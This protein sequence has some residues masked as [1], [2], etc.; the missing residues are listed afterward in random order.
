[1]LSA[2]TGSPAA[3]LRMPATSVSASMFFTRKPHA[4]SRSAVVSSSA[5]SDT[6]RITT[7]ADGTSCTSS[8]SV[9]S[10]DSPGMFRSSRITSG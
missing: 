8:C 2:I 6:V 4:P 1:M 3:A 9:S 10:P 7:C 5:S